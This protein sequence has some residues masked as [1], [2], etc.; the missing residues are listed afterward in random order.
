M[1]NY[2]LSPYSPGPWESGSGMFGLILDAKGRQVA[3]CYPQTAKRPDVPE[4]GNACMI[5]NAPTMHDFLVTVALA[6]GPHA[7]EAQRIIEEIG[8]YPMDEDE[9]TEIEQVYDA[10]GPVAGLAMENAHGRRA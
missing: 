10:R 4:F 9:P 2:P 1:R 7:A 6:G 8:V 5:R 3:S